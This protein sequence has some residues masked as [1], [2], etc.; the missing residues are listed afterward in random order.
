METWLRVG[1]TLPGVLSSTAPHCLMVSLPDI[2]LRR[3]L[4]GRVHQQQQQHARGGL[5]GDAI[6]TMELNR[7][8]SWP[9]TTASCCRRESSCIARSIPGEHERSWTWTM[10]QHHR[11]A[12][13]GTANC[14]T[15]LLHC[16]DECCTHPTQCVLRVLHLCPTTHPLQVC[17]PSPY[18][19]LCAFVIPSLL[20]SSFLLRFLTL[21][22]SFTTFHILLSHKSC[23]TCTLFPFFP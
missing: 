13:R 21:L 12:G 9:G 22:L 18:L 1:V 5:F 2:V 7:R 3:P 19:Y 4:S 15:G 14:K 6:L 17:P 10:A 23:F 16:I 20:L 11:E 8:G